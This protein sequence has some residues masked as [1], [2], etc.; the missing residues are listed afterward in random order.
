MNWKIEGANLEL[1]VASCAL[2]CKNQRK[3]YV[4]WEMHAP[5]LTTRSRSSITRRCTRPSSV[6]ATLQAQD[7]ASMEIFAR[8]PTVSL[9]FQSIW[10]R[11]L[12]AMPTSI[13]ITS[14]QHGVLIKSAI[15]NERS[16]SMLITGKISVVSHISIL[17]GRNSALLGILSTR[18]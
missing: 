4:L 17:T 6:R 7:S 2:K 8:L 9:K 14:R 16:A 12:T 15:T 1:I 10:L 13:C 5:S 18:L 3:R 11:G